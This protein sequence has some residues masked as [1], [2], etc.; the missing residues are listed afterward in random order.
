M[1]AFLLLLLLLFLPTS[2]A[3]TCAPTED[4]PCPPVNPPICG[5]C[6]S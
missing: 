2:V 1:K 5:I 6:V 4:N 3:T